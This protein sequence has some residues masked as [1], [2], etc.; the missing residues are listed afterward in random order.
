MKNKIII[1]SLLAV[2]AGLTI[3]IALIATKHRN[4]KENLNPLQSVLITD[5]EVELKDNTKKYSISITCDDIKDINQQIIYYQLK[6]VFQDSKVKISTLVLKD[7]EIITDLSKGLTAINITFDVTTP[8]NIE[9]LYYV[10][11]TCE[12]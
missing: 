12:K 6:P 10:E 3:T 7:K 1:G 8:D 5:K 4:F 2:I 11:A 9:Q